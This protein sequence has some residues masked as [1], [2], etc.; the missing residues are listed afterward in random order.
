MTTGIIRKKIFKKYGYVRTSMKR[1]SLN[2]A[3]SV[4]KNILKTSVF[5]Y[6]LQQ[7]YIPLEGFSAKLVNQKFESN[8]SVY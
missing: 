5:Q 4:N 2:M 8:F 7:S 6:Q 1:I 3:V